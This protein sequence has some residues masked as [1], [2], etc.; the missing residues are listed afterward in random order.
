MVIIMYKKV[1]NST[2]L[3]IKRPD[4]DQLLS[5]VFHNAFTKTAR[6]IANNNTS[7]VYSQSIYY[8]QK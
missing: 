6:Y 8:Y 4:L 3:V 2:I 5:H 1:I 7:V